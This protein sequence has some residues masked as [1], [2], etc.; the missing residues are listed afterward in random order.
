M[1]ND[2]T[3]DAINLPNVIAED[4]TGKPVADKRLQADEKVK[5]K[6]EH[7]GVLRDLRDN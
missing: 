7:S 4:T 1:N 3:K 5:G 2:R 6:V